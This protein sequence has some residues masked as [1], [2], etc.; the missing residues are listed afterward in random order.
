MLMILKILALV[1]VWMVLPVF[2]G[3]VFR[4]SGK[5]I[6]NDWKLSYLLGILSIW[7]VYYATARWAITEEWTLSRLSKVWVG[8]LILISAITAGVLLHKKGLRL[9]RNAVNFKGIA[10]AVL[11]LV[12]IVTAAELSLNEQQEHTVEEV[13]TMY[14]TDSLYQYNPMSGRPKEELLSIEAEALEQ[15]AKSPIGAYYAVYVMLFKIYPAK[16]VRILLPIFLMP[17]YFL[18]YAAWGNYLF[19]KYTKKQTLFQI[20]V[21]LL[22]GT[23]LF[24]E[25]SWVFNIFMNCWNGETL[26]FLGVLPLAVLLLLGGGEKIRDFEEFKAP[27]L[28]AEYAA[29]AGAGQLLYKKGFFFVT[30]IWGIALIALAIKRWKDGDSITAIEE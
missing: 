12:L 28:W 11:L 22:Y 21:W 14:T 19:P 20:T 16:F 3:E 27:L 8:M 30:F 1:Y 10:K 18:V 25:R 23:A 24:T 26:F 9:N 13:L 5:N 17:F 6:W 2:V 4:L 29:C 15:S 7:T